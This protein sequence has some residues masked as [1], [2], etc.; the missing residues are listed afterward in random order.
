MRQS[1]V[2]QN[3]MENQIKINEHSLTLLK[4]V[5]TDAETHKILNATI[6]LVDVDKNEVLATFKSNSATGAYVVSL[7]AGR[8]YGIAV[9]AKNYL[10][11]SE[12]FNIPESD[13][14]NE[15]VLNIN[16]YKIK[17]GSSIRL[18]NIFFAYQKADLTPNSQNE[19]D[20][21]LALM[22]ENPKIK[23]EVS[24]HTDNVGSRD[25]NLKLSTQRAKSVYDYLI[26]KGVKESRI[27][28]VGY[29]FDKP[30]ADNSSES[31]R[32]LNRRSEIKVIGD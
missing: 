31:G 27:T 23:I 5:I 12:N 19:L 24:G 15:E 3:V 26:S 9:K 17:V 8:N 28:Y 22:E 30:V 7:P 10:F 13:G 14:Y 29:G 2:V 18:N 11:H 6:E 20:R 21:V 32:K 16:L 1:G 4:G 25:Y